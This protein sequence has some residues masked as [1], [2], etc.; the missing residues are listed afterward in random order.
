M[1]TWAQEAL[2]TELYFCCNPVAWI[3]HIP[4]V[5]HGPAPRASTVTFSIEADR[6]KDPEAMETVQLCDAL[7]DKLRVV[8]LYF[9]GGWCPLCVEFDK[10]LREA[11]SGLKTLPESGD[12]ELI[13]VSCDLSEALYKEH[14]RQ[15]GEVLAVPWGRTHLEQVAERF[16]VCGIPT[17]LI[18]NAATG[19]VVNDSGREDIVEFSALLKRPSS[20]VGSGSGGSAPALK[21]GKSQAALSMS[22]AVSDHRGIRRTST[23]ADLPAPSLQRGISMGGGTAMHKQAASRMASVALLHRWV[24]ACEETKLEG[25]DLHTH[26]EDGHSERHSPL[27][28]DDS[29]PSSGQ[30]GSRMNP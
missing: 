2:G 23:S 25:Q 24:Q 9:S 19:E 27:L 5:P 3:P 28:P 16:E 29:S 30:H 13:W 26:S 18:L 20:P 6:A 14:L 21:R 10:Q 7:S 8:L 17:L 1:A 11:Y 15:L 4:A 22:R 12:V